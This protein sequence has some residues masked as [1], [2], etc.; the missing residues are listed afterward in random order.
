MSEQSQDENVGKLIRL[1]QLRISQARAKIAKIQEGFEGS[2][3]SL[4][5]AKKRITDLQET[6]AKAEIE[7]QRLQKAVWARRSSTADINATREELKAL[8]DKNLDATTFEEKLD[9]VSRLGIRVYPSEDLKAMRVLCEVNLDRGH[10]D[11]RIA[12]MKSED[13]QAN[14]ESESATECGKVMFNPP[15]KRE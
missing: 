11:T 13:M 15:T 3:Y 4:D 7:I 6:V 9:I 2:I 8:R 1:Q 14:A 12:E 5:E 10:L